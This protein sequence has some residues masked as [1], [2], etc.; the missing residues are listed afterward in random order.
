M[1]RKALEEEA[2]E[3]AD[4]GCPCCCCSLWPYVSSRSCLLGCWASLGAAGRF[5]A[6]PDPAKLKSMVPGGNAEEGNEG[7]RFD[8][9]V[10]LKY[11]VTVAVL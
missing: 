7:R 6:L 10:E 4:G 11:R 8:R 5:R 1:N 3:D 9:G 2:A